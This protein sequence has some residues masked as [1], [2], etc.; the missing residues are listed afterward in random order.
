MNEQSTTKME[1]N[2]SLV[3]KVIFEFL[4]SLK[5]NSKIPVDV[6]AALAKLTAQGKLKDLVGLQAAVRVALPGKSS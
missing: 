3:D 1:K 4:S 5:G 6:I 2:E